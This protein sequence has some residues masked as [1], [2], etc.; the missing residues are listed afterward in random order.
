MSTMGTETYNGSTV[1]KLNETISATGSINKTITFNTVYKAMDKDIKYSI[2][3]SN[4][5]TLNG[6]SFPTGT[7]NN[8]VNTTAGWYFPSTTTKPE[9]IT[10]TSP[11][12]YDANTHVTSPGSYDFDMTPQKASN[13]I[14][15]FN[16]KNKAVGNMNIKLNIS[17]N[18]VSRTTASGTSAL[19]ALTPG[20]MPAN[21][22]WVEATSA[23]TNK[24][25][26]GSSTS[27][28]NSWVP[29]SSSE[30]LTI[31]G[32]CN[33]LS[34]STDLGGS[35]YGYYFY[36]TSVGYVSRYGTGS[37]GSPYSYTGSTYT[38]LYYKRSDASSWSSKS[39]SSL[40][41]SS[42]YYADHNWSAHRPSS[43]STYYYL[44]RIQLGS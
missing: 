37:P 32:Y 19:R 8:L 2:T 40:S 21:I 34:T 10:S 30:R 44:K 31:T 11:M 1:W 12:S 29:D 16:T 14:I 26:K 9:I 13:S 36:V 28:Y 15:V 33:S 27:N 20:W 3:F 38:I 35:T 4:L 41:G 43:D 5:A 25:Y 39:T 24:S 7:G 17:L 18:E 22:M 42:G 6:T 23:G